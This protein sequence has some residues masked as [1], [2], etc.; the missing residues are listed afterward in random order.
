MDKAT[1]IEDYRG[2]AYQQAQRLHKLAPSRISFDDALQVVW[3]AIW[4]AANAY[5]ET[6]NRAFFGY[7]LQHIKWDVAHYLREEFAAGIRCK[8]RG[9]RVVQDAPSTEVE[10]TL[11]ELVQN[12]K[13]D[14]LPQLVWDDIRSAL[15]DRELDVVEAIWQRGE[16]EQDIARRWETSSAYVN[17]VKLAAYRKLKR[18]Y[19]ND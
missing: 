18:L 6:H 14:E 13:D 10:L 7:A 15:V 5:N 11:L 3:L 4:K 2:L 8:P 9:V 17:L 1:V 12:R 16:S 19:L